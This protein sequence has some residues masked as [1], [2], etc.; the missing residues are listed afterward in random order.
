M[1][2]QQ[3]V[4]MIDRYKNT[5]IDPVEMLNWTWMRVFINQISEDDFDRYIKETAEIC[6]G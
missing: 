1:T 6:A 2:K 4:Q 5:L 3:M